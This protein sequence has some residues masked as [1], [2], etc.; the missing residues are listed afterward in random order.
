[1]LIAVADRIGEEYRHE[2]GAVERQTDGRDAAEAVATAPGIGGVMV[3]L[4]R[5]IRPGM[6]VVAGLG[7]RLMMSRARMK[8]GMRVAADDCE[9]KQQDEG[10]EKDEAHA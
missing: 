9:R 1:M 4:V 10:S 2:A 8:L 7:A 5:R 6:V 3:S